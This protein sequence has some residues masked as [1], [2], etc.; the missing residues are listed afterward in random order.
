MRDYAVFVNTDANGRETVTR[1]FTCPHCG[2]VNRMVKGYERYFC[3]KHMLPTCPTV[4]CAN[5]CDDLR[6]K[7]D[8]MDKLAAHRR[9]RG[10]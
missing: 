10:Y 9:S 6:A 5:A 3:M 7:F 4:A 1:A 8:R 2:K